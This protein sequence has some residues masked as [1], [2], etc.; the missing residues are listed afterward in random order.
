MMPLFLLFLFVLAVMSVPIEFV[1]RLRQQREEAPVPLPTS[2]KSPPEE[3]RLPSLLDFAKLCSARYVAIEA[4]T[5]KLTEIPVPLDRRL[6]PRKYVV[7]DLGGGLMTAIVLATG[8]KLTEK[9]PQGKVVTLLAW[10][11]EPLLFIGDA[12]SVFLASDEPD[13]PSGPS[14]S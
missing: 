9:Y 10:A 7:G 1:Y 5:A 12:E 11:D 2:F 8:R 6:D 3:D 13:A 14:D 4:G